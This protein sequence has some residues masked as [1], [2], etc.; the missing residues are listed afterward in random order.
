MTT[1][2]PSTLH[3]AIL[4]GFERG[5][6]SWPRPDGLAA[7]FA[8]GGKARDIVELCTRLHLPAIFLDRDGKAFF[9][10]SDVAGYLDRE[11]EVEDGQ[12][13]TDTGRGTALL[14][15]AV[16]RAVC[17]LDEVASRRAIK[18]GGHRPIYATI[19][20]YPNRSEYQLLKVIVVLG[21]VAGDHHREIDAL[22]QMLNTR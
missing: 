18:L 15:E 6:A 10:S 9:A 8:E 7:P 16:S 3:P 20:D 12:L 5:I 17:A 13:F 14:Q 22:E 2:A 21:R 4:D 11:I 1:D 19:L